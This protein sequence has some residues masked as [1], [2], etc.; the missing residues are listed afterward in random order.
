MGVEEIT[1][2][3]DGSKLVPQTNDDW[4]EWVSTTAT[5]NFVLDDPI[6]DWLDLYGEENG[7]QRDTAL[8]HHDPRTSFIEFIF[9]KGNEFE[10]AVVHLLKQK[11]QIKQIAEVPAD[12]RNSEFAERTFSAM[13]DGAPIISQGVLMDPQHQTY[14]APDLLV[15]SDVLA[16]LFPQILSAEDAAISAPD[17]GHNGWHYRVVDIK[18]HTLGLLA[19]GETD[20]SGS[21]PAYKAQLYIYNQALGRLQGFEPSESYLI[22]RGW[23]QGKDRGT[24]CLER[25]GPITQTGT[26]ANK[27]PIGQLTVD[28]TNWIR[29]LRSEGAGWRVLPTPTVPEIYPDAGNQSDEPWHVAKRKIA[30]ELKELTRLWQ[31]GVPGRR[32]AHEARI[33]HWDDPSLTLDLVKVTGDKRPR[34]LAEIIAVNK[35]SD[36]V[37]RPARINAEREV[38]HQPEAIE[39]Y[40]DFEFVSDLSD[41]FTRMPEKGGQP[42]IFMIGCGHLEDS[43]WSF[44]SFTVDVL[45]ETSEAAIIEEWIEHMESVRIRL[46]PNRG[47]PILFHWSHAEVTTFQNAYKSARDRHPTQNWPSLRWFDFLGNVVREEPVVVKGA[48][49][50]GLK[51]VSSAFHSQGLIETLWGDGP[52]DGLGAMVAAWWCDVEARKRNEPLSSID[53]MQEVIEYNE[54]DCKVM[55]EIIGYLR[56]NH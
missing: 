56:A 9:K 7:F 35:E 28:A 5:R 49:G 33:F 12:V 10:S 47:E 14:G 51:A 38:W 13:E 18:F 30:E 43:Q 32:N 8:E 11:Y 26:V 39:F 31:V 23:R 50:F 15:R 25:L 19:S 3:D 48:F 54:V 34:V 36:P 4:R 40:V 21:A 24:S 46:A 37:V 55:M 45:C 53:L 27:H 52:S 6:L 42:L 17:L 29:R 20:N 22:G 1:H 2:L 41:D 16:D 44:K